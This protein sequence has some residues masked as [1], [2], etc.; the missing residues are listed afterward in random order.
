M[1]II[2]IE[3]DMHPVLGTFVYN[4]TD[5]KSITLLVSENGSGKTR[6]MEF[7]HSLLDK[8]FRVWEIA[9]WQSASTERIK[10]SFQ[11]TKEECALLPKIKRQKQGSIEI[12]EEIDGNM[13][14][15]ASGKTQ[16][17][18]DVSIFT[19]NK[20]SGSYQKAN[21]LRPLLTKNNI[22]DKILK[23]KTRFS[24][25]EINY[26]EPKVERSGAFNLDGDVQTKS[27]KDLAQITADLLVSLSIE[28]D[29][30]FRKNNSKVGE[31][32]Q[33]FTGKFDRFKAAY[34]NLFS[35]GIK[36][37]GVETENSEY[38]VKFMNLKTSKHFPLKGLSSGQQQVVYRLG[39]LLQ[40]INIFAGG[41]V[42]IDE[43]EL[44]LHPLWQ[45]RY[46]K[47]LQELFGINIQFIIA[48]HSPYI[49]KSGISNAGVEI[50]KIGINAS[51]LV[52]ENLSRR[53]KLGSP[54]LAEISYV[55]FGVVTE[56]LHIELYLELEKKLSPE[57]WDAVN[58]KYVGGTPSTLDSVLRAAPLNIPIYKIW[59][60]INSKKIMEETIMTFVRNGIHHGK[61]SIS[62]GR[63]M[64]TKDELRQAIDKML[65]IL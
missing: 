50:S 14:F 51:G 18:D 27:P 31:T 19:F 48:T 23:E 30:D 28:D 36:L 20:E 52:N 61:N 59:T 3:V 29:R 7:L 38:V 45:E 12:E 49:V 34:N 56:E 26:A 53:S 24:S 55:A 46:L 6:F 9:E 41:I 58:K 33:K 1:R 39:Y 42:F 64:Y 60:D 37:L 35:D 40:N 44:S 32:I 21:E 22:F 4:F 2:S 16:S 13:F 17:W 10:L 47:F 62:R 15:L 65:L 5:G 8:G 43:P 54:T 63:D 11:L 25:V 57:S